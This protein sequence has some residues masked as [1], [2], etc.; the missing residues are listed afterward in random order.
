[1]GYPSDFN[2][3]LRSSRPSALF[4]EILSPKKT[5]SFPSFRYIGKVKVICGKD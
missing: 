3:G 5:K 1:M 2:F 4:T